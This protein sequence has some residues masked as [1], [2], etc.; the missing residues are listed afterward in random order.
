M[1]RT[2]YSSR[3]VLPYSVVTECDREASITRQPWPNRGLLRDGKIYSHK[4]VAN[5]VMLQLYLSH[6][7]YNRA[8][9]I[10]ENFTY[11]PP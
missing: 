9:K 6:R 1:C 8:F 7:F 10:I 11:S 5:S 3:W 2:N 4:A